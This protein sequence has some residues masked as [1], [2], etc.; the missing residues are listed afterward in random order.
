MY[1]KIKKCSSIANTKYMPPKHI[2]EEIYFKNNKSFKKIG[3][4]YG[5]S[6]MTVCLWFKKYKIK[7]KTKTNYG[8]VMPP[9]HE[10]LNV[11]REKKSLNEMVKIYNVSRSSIYKWIK[12]YKIPIKQKVCKPTRNVLYDL[13][14]N[15][16][17]TL[18]EISKMYNVDRL[19][20]GR[21]M[22]NYNIQTRFTKDKPTKEILYNLY[23]VKKHTLKEISKMCSLHETTISNYLK[24]YNIPSRAFKK[25][26]T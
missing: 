21:W 25:N 23:I 26:I 2:L 10:L 18:V 9:R 7:P 14:N 22:K 4:L 8:Y 13:Y 16:K 17:H 20:I 12:H 5:V 15:K 24:K 6:D 19:T 3:N 1:D 11:L